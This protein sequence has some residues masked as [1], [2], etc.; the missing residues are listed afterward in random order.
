MKR[1]RYLATLWHEATVVMHP[2]TGVGAQWPELPTA[3]AVHPPLQRRVA[4]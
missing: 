4:R 2:S 1:A 3:R